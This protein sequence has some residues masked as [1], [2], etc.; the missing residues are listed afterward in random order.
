MADSANK[1]RRPKG[2]KLAQAAGRYT[3]QGGARQT[4]PVPTGGGARGKKAG[5]RPGVR[6]EATRRRRWINYP[7]AGKGPVMRWIPGWRFFL[8]SFLMLIILAVGAFA[9]AYAMIKVPDPSEFAIA[10]T[11]TVYYAD[12]TTKMGEFAD[13]DRTIID[14]S[15]LPDYIGNAVVANEDRSLDRKSVV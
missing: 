6:R 12:G 4:G 11:S 2:T 9:V 14:T 7:R 10:E 15:G 1:G 5:G 3:G 13:V 8:G